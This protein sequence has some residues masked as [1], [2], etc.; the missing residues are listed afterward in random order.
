VLNEFIFLGHIP[1]TNLQLTFSEIVAL[2]DIAVGVYFLRKYL[3]VPQSLKRHIKH[4]RL[5]LSL[6][7]GTQLSLPV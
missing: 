6:P 1:G 7:K 2:V 4:L 3:V 5:Y